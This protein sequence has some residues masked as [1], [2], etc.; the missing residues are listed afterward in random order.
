MESWERFDDPGEGVRNGEARGCGLL[1]IG[2]LFLWMRRRV[3]A[4]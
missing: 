3:A 1:T 2:V 4:T